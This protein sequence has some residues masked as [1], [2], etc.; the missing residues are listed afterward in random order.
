MECA[1]LPISN[2]RS[3]KLYQEGNSSI[4]RID[5]LRKQSVRESNFLSLG[6]HF[7]RMRSNSLVSVFCNDGEAPVTKL[8]FIVIT[9]LSI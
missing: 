2:M 1:A 8:R 3:V 4:C 7:S 5:D 9:R 6:S